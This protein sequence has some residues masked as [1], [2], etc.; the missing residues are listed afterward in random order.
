MN[1]LVNNVLQVE[2]SLSAEKGA[3]SLFALFLREESVEKWDLVISAPWIETDKEDALNLISSKVREALNLSELLAV[4]RIV[5]VEPTSPAVVAINRAFAVD[6]SSVEVRDANFFGL[7][8]KHAH[9]F[10]SR[11][12]ESAVPSPN[13]ALARLRRKQAQH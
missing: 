11:Q 9:I 12:Q 13:R 1:D 6:H 10:A 7:A 3:F 2:R 5:L 8:I 4:S